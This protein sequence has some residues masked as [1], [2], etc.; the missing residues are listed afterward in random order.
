MGYTCELIWDNGQTLSLEAIVSQSTN[1]STLECVVPDEQK[2]DYDGPEKVMKVNVRIKIKSSETY[3]DNSQD[4][5]SE[6]CHSSSLALEFRA[7]CLIP[8][9]IY[10]NAVRIWYTA[11]FLLLRQSQMLQFFLHDVLHMYNNDLLL[12]I[13]AFDGLSNEFLFMSNCQI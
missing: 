7:C 4:S 8:G 13:V 3:L 10:C 12:C 6:C 2:L 11:Q 1:P 5:Y 9:L